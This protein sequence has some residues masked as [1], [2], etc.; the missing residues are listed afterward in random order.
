MEIERDPHRNFSQQ[1]W[2]LIFVRVVAI[3][4][5]QRRL[6]GLTVLILWR[7][8]N[9][10]PATGRQNSSAVLPRN[11]LAGFDRRTSSTFSPRRAVW[12]V[13]EMLNSS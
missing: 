6:D 8:L 2:L 13:A 1:G 5:C 12:V 3:I 9:R 7:T 10:D 11:S 4:G